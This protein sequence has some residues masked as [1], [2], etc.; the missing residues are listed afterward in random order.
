[1]YK[2][3]IG[4]FKSVVKKIKI[5]SFKMTWVVRHRWEEGAKK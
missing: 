3:N 4:P 5:G 2:I 1:M